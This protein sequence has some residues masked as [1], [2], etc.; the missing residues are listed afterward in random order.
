MILVKV[1]TFTIFQVIGLT[2][3]LIK[4]GLLKG[5]SM[6]LC[7]VFWFVGEE[8]VKVGLIHP[9]TRDEQ[10]GYRVEWINVGIKWR[11]RSNCLIQSTLLQAFKSQLKQLEEWRK[12]GHN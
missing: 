9:P 4:S 6:Y 5:F 2:L 1:S 10:H 8:Q 7:S 12:T 3:A 11:G